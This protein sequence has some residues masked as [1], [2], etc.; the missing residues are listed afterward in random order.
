MFSFIGLEFLI[1]GMKL[2]CLT[3]AFGFVYIALMET[4][5]FKPYSEKLH[6]IKYFTLLVLLHFSV[7]LAVHLSLVLFHKNKQVHIFDLFFSIGTH[8]FIIILKNPIV[9]L[10]YQET[11]D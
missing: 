5:K 7:A 10:A 8:L 11:I 9:A 4:T 2:P 1:Y 3:S 6:N